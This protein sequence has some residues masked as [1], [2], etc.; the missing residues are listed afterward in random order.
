MKDP[1]LRAVSIGAR[2]LWIDILCLA[3][4]SPARG[5]LYTAARKPYTIDQIARACGLTTAEAE[6]LVSELIDTGVCSRR[7]DGSISSRRMVRDEMIRSRERLKKQEDRRKSLP[8]IESVPL[9]VPEPVPTVSPPSSSS[10]SS[11]EETTSV[12][13][14][15]DCT[16]TREADF[17]TPTDPGFDAFLR[18]FTAC[19][20]GAGTNDLK[21][22]R[23]SW[24]QTPIT[25]RLVAVRYAKQ[26]ALTEWRSRDK[27][28]IPR[29]WNF[30]K[31]RHWERGDPPRR[32][33]KTTAKESRTQLLMATWAKG[34]S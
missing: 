20:I 7:K 29:P 18:V 3:W 19:G 1:A 9:G 6:M 34:E 26:Q 22:M 28:H 24:S 21:R 13:K 17:D 2:G 5:I 31:E 16:L 8:V 27:T 10:S 25:D 15:T 33:P 12:Q 30:L 11:S 14:Q 4:E 32:I 23:Q